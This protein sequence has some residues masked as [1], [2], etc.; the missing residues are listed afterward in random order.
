VLVFE[1]E[2]YNL[3]HLTCK[4]LSGATCYIPMLIRIKE[5]YILIHM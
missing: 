1:N 3:L 5:Y 2:Y 4:E